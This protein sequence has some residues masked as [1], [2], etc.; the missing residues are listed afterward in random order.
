MRAP[1]NILH[2]L[3]HSL[4]LHSGY[5]FRSQGLL[6][7]QQAMGFHPVILTGPKHEQSWKGTWAEVEEINGLAHYRTGAVPSNGHLPVLPEVRLVRAMRR[8]LEQVVELE[9][10]HVLHAHSPFLNALPALRTAR[11]R[12]IPLVYEIRAFWEDAAVDHGTYT[13]GSWRYRL[14]RAM[15]T[16]V[17]R[18]A[19]QVTV[20]CRS[21]KQDLVRRGVPGSKITVISN[22]IRPDA[23]GPGA[24]DEAFRRDWNLEGRIVIGFVGSFYRYEGLD[25]LVRAFARIA[26][27]HPGLTLLLVG[28]GETEEE[29]KALARTLGTA[30]TEA[31]PELSG[32]SRP[33]I[34]FPGR[35]PHERIPGIYALM[36]TLVYP[37]RAM[38]LT[39]LVTPLKPLEAMAMGKVVAASD[40]G[41]HRELIE[42]GVNG[43]LFPPGDAV[44]LAATLE[45]LLRKPEGLHRIGS[46]AAQVASER[47]SW[48]HA[49]VPY[50]AVYRTAVRRRKGRR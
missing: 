34:L 48:E 42:P 44:A 6:Q 21:L 25:L 5:A 46:R 33:R 32:G 24:P 47:F 14:V 11:R 30:V 1:L 28:G 7:A 29:L 16:R 13:E 26:P 50:E 17:C 2:L 36:D 12:G 23:F 20:L 10:P 35:L 49:T 39:E 31:P 3:D 18:R 38:R 15:E 40:V 22:G 27:R 37:R 8:R 19:D 9:R 43:I 4:P 45:S 41:G